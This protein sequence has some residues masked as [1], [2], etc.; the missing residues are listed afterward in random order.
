MFASGTFSQSVL[1]YQSGTGVVV[2]P[3]ADVCAD[4]IK[5]NGTFSGG[6]PICGGIVYVLNLT[7]FIEG[8]FNSSLSYFFFLSILTIGLSFIKLFNI[9][10]AYFLL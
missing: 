1:N 5:I 10:I 3:G 6:G 8:F 7:G 2:E 9:L 4:Q